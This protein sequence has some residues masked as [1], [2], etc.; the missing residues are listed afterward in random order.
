[1]LAPA[2]VDNVLGPRW[3][4]T[5]PV[6]RVLVWVNVVGLLGDALV[7]LLRGLGRPSRATLL[8]LVQSTLLVLL[9]WDLAGRFGALGAALTWLIATGAS[10]LLGIYLLRH[11]LPRAW[12][13]SGL[14]LTATVA[15]ALAGAAA[16]WGIL[17]VE[18]GLPGLLAAAGGGALATVAILWILDRRLELNLARDLARAFPNVVT[19]WTL[20]T[21]FPRA[22]SATPPGGGTQ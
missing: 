22:Q 20:V 17:R 11:L 7:P 15:A 5:V 18:N 16:A 1:V 14:A 12:V 13:G 8:G 4:G 3:Q 19:G 9:A 10:Q 6:I 21:G 2:L